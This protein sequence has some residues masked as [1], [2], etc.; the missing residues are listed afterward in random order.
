MLAG[1]A[2]L[3]GATASA[4]QAQP[5]TNGSDTNGNY[6]ET[7]M[8][9]PRVGGGGGG[10]SGGVPLP[11]PLTPSGAARIK[12]VL[13]LQAR[14]EIPAALRL[15]ADGIDPL[16]RGYVTARRLL[17]PY[18][19]P[20][21]AELTD[22]LARYG[23][24]PD[25]PAV[26]ALLR[27]RLP[28]GTATPPAPDVPTLP[29]ASTSE[30]LPEDAETVA[31]SFV[32]NQLLD[33]TV[34]A[35]ARAGDFA[36]ALRLIAATKGLDPAYRRQLRA[37][38]AQIR[39]TLNDDS[40][41]L[42]TATA[43]LND[44]DGTGGPV[45]LAGYVAGLASWRLDQ[46]SAASGYFIA[47]ARAPNTSPALRAAAAFWAARA[48]LWLND[49]PGYNRWMHRAADEPRT[50]HGMIARRILGLGLG[51]GGVRETLGEAD[52]DALGATPN[53]LRAFALLQVGEIDAAETELR[54]LWPQMDGDPSMRR[55]ILL[56]AQHAGMME[57]AAQLA[58]ILQASDGRPRDLI[59]FPVPRLHP[60][61]GF[62][63]D[64][65]LVYA[66]TRLESNFDSGAVSHVG[67]RGLMQLM[68]VTASYIAGDPSIGARS[69]HDPAVNL[70][71]GQRYV[72]YLAHADA[73]DG[74]LIRLLASY[75]SGPGKVATWGPAIRDDGDPFMF[76]EAIPNAET[77]GFVQHALTYTWI[78][79]A[80]LGLPAPSLDALALGHWPVFEPGFTPR[81][82]RPT[83][84][85]SDA[86]MH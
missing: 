65:A 49:D 22:W 39:F 36:S 82:H 21:P 50:F 20:T 16:L 19:H 68:P 9:V 37:E 59:R 86:L 61:G 29:S 4:A 62:L 34:D 7:A 84:E 41:A 8:A 48:R 5:K 55:A 2:L 83:L 38:V 70:E 12:R 10:A 6:D 47:A 43:A 85:M 53:G 52:A 75:N 66:L 76:I 58:S 64:P 56:V 14:G 73:V 78:Y 54:A 32:R 15:E 74:D 27:R 81:P 25:A 63:V 11:Q 30:P 46:V 67:A 44:T 69:L 80:R 60:H 33:R 23:S 1:A 13:A 42:A 18:Y 79:A 28:S 57:F 26:H 3:A 77:R 17:G 35:R 71:L 45:A 24:Q 51:F 40:G 72:A 31:R